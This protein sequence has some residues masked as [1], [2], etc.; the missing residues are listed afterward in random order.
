VGIDYHLGFSVVLVEV[1]DHPGD[2]G[3][4]ALKLPHTDFPDTC[5]VD[6][7]VKIG[8][9]QFGVE[10]IHNKPGRIWEQGFLM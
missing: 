7:Q 3:L 1:D 6:L 5:R 2:L 9:G 4:R 10:Q 8:G